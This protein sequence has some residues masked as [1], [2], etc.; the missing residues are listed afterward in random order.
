MHGSAGLLPPPHSS[1]LSNLPPFY[2]L[3]SPPHDASIFQHHR[4]VFMNS[5][6]IQQKRSPNSE[7]SV[8]SKAFDSCKIQ[9]MEDRHYDPDLSHNDRRD[10]LYNKVLSRGAIGTHGVASQLPDR[11]SVLNPTVAP[12]ALEG[13]SFFTKMLLPRQFPEHFSRSTEITAYTAHQAASSHPSIPPPPSSLGGATH[14][15]V[16]APSA[17]QNPIQPCPVRFFPP[18]FR[19]PRNFLPYQSHFPF[20]PTDPLLPYPS[21]MLFPRSTRNP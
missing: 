14:P 21:S 11:D 17:L 2:A 9:N 10:F 19:W 20:M 15:S 18:E 4:N 12:G 7:Y 6:A 3:P 8:M 16:D 13:L 5:H 1:Y